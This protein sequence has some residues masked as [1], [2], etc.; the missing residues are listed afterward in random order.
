MSDAKQLRGQVRQLLPEVLSNELVAEVEKRLIALINK[1]MDEIEKK[2]KDILGFMVRQAS[3][4]P[5][6]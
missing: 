5:N 3:K 2:H 6:T 1:R 4:Q